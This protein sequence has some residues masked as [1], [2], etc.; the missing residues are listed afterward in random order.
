MPKTENFR[1]VSKM[2]YLRRTTLEG[3]NIYEDNVYLEKLFKTNNIC[4]K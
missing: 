4:K 1:G 2:K 3:K